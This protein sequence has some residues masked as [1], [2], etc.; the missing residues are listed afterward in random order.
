MLKN[1]YPHVSIVVPVYN[2]EKYLTQCIDSILSQDFTNF[3]LLLINDGSKDS[4]GSICDIYAQKDKRIKVFHKENGGV[5]SAR[6]LGIDKAQGEYIT[7]I[8]SDDYINSDFISTLTSSTAD[9]VVTGCKVLNNNKSIKY[10]YTYKESILSTSQNIADCLSQTL[11]QLPFWAPWCKLFKLEIIRQH[12]IYFNTQI[13]QFEDS[14]FLHTYLLY[15][16]TIAI[17]SGTAYNYITGT[18]P[19]YKRTLSE[20]EYLYH[21]QIT[22]QAYNNITKYFN[23]K[24]INFEKEINKNL[25]LSYF[26]SITQRNYTLQG[27]SKFKQ[28]MKQQCPH[29]VSFS[30]KLLSL[31]YILLEKRMYF[32]AF[33][34][35]RFIYPLKVNLRHHKLF[36]QPNK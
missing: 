5:S 24:C 14:I 15:C 26:R 19:I 11:N 22:Y 30:D 18:G 2:A 10:K 29:H 32:F 1:Y 23:F 3:E 6:N 16:Q 33:L 12:A 35:L 21:L 7:F 8:D 9:L 17:R 13:K 31:T 20:S 4:S 28:I 34:L 25:L 27:Y 36:I